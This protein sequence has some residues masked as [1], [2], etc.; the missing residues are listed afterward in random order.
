MFAVVSAMMLLAW[1][2]VNFKVLKNDLLRSYWELHQSQSE[3]ELILDNTREAVITHSSE[4][5]IK[6]LN[7]A[8]HKLLTFCINQ[9]EAPMK[10]DC[11]RELSRI[12]ERSRIGNKFELNQALQT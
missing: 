6:Y 1:I 8:G 10:I 4:F 11:L 2:S 5:G 9:L 12:K 7:Q 3:I